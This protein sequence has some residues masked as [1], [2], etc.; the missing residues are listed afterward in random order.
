[1]ASAGFVIVIAAFEAP[2][3]A[4]GLDDVAV[5]D[6]AVEQLGRHL[7][8]AERAG[9]FAERMCGCPVSTALNF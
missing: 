9:P 6:Q 5:V 7:G 3:I 4:A 8:I 2:A 1:M